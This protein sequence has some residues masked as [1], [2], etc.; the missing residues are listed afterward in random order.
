MFEC[1]WVTEVHTCLEVAGAYRSSCLLGS[2]HLE[3]G[4]LASDAEGS[5][6]S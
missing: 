3:C 5:D 2:R 1:A 4:A 6:H